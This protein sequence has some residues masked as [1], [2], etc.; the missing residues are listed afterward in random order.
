MK[1]SG[2]GGTTPAFGVVL[3][4]ANNL[5]AD[6]SGTFGVAPFGDP[7]ATYDGETLD[8]KGR[9]DLHGEAS[10][11]AWSTRSGVEQRVRRTV[12]FDR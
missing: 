12:W 7:D 8:L 6:L 3:R 2:T 5:A 11:P 10:E 4:I 9:N 1:V